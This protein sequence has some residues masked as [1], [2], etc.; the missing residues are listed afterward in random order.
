MAPK[1]RL[2]KSRGD[3]KVT[4]VLGGI[5]EYFDVDPSFV[6]IVFALATVLTGI[7]PFVFLYVLM[8]FIVPE[9]PEEPEAGG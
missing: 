2:Y 6:R 8:A 1:K 5:A 3:R 9:A 7:F 4:G